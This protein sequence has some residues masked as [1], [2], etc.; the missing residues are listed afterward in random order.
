MGREHQGGGVMQGPPRVC[1]NP[2]EKRCTKC[3]EVKP[4]AAFNKRTPKYDAALRV[5]ESQ[6]RAC[7]KALHYDKD[8]ARQKERN[9]LDRAMALRHYS[10]G[11]PKCACCGEHRQEFLCFDHINGDGAAHRKVYKSPLPGWL[12]R[13][14]YPASFQVLCFNCNFAKRQNARCP[15]HKWDGVIV[16][17]FVD[18][19]GSA[20]ILP[21]THI[22]NGVVIG[23][24]VSIGADCVIG[25][26]SYIGAGSVIGNRSRLQTGV[27]L[28]NLSMLGE[29]VFLGPHAVCTDDRYPRVNNHS[30]KA[31]PPIFEDRCS[32]GAGAVI[33]PG[34]RVGTGA[35]IGAG[36]VVTESVPDHAIV[37]GNPSRVVRLKKLGEE[38]KYERSGIP[39]LVG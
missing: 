15:H 1:P 9:N 24:D 32:I 28:P 35:M 8:L 11:D 37:I 34:V 4:V 27:F 2:T 7:K 25:S 17:K 16:H 20:I 18:I 14:N 38:F 5:P 31:E 21:G 3:G 13:H 29:D 36:C 6:C 26:N 12:R 22:W 30:Y 39:A 10:K 19:H 23:A 33:L